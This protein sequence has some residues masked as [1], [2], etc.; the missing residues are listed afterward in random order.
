MKCSF[1]S[2]VLCFYVACTAAIPVGKAEDSTVLQS[3]RDGSDDSV[4]AA[5]L[6]S[7]QPD[8]VFKRTFGNNPQGIEASQERLHPS[9]ISGC[10][11]EPMIFIKFPQPEELSRRSA[12]TD[13]AEAAALKFPQPDVVFK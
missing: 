2:A 9:K 4:E 12:E 3:R 13:D 7:P 10:M 1:V 5:A 6:V 11:E 8:T